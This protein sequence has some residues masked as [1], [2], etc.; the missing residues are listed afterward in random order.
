M[1]TMTRKLRLAAQGLSAAALLMSSSVALAQTSATIP[2]GMQ[3]TYELTFTGSG[4]GPAPLPNGT[5][6]DL[7][8]APGGATCIADYVLTSPTLQ[9]GNSV[10]AIYAVPSLGIKLA[11]SNVSTGQF[12]EVNVMS[13]SGQFLGQFTG[14]KKSTST[15]CPLLGSA[16]ADLTDITQII[17][18]AEQQFG[19][20]FPSAVA[21]NAFQII[22]GFVSRN[23]TTSG[24]SIG[25]KNGTVYVAGGAFG[26]TPQTIG[27]IANTL[28]QLTGGPGVEEP[29]VEVPEGDY[30]LT[31][32]GTVSAT[33]LGFTTTTPL[34]VTIDKIPAPDSSDI[35]EIEDDVREAL[36]NAEG[37]DAAT[38]TSFRVSEVS[39]S[40]SRVFFRVQFSGTIVSSG[41][42]VQQSYNLTYEYIKQ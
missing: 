7:V 13:T 9:S 10:E 12:N 31:I 8:L 34:N 27:T 36:K 32:S 29:V 40:N 21:N 17:K 20:L 41:I 42:T 30:K 25:I 19:D 24:V 14:V 37:V 28:A 16:Q 18:L 2:A 15:S 38:F 6:L 11:I 3:G 35:D 33:V 39:T 22:D 5:K 4:S 1:E 26:N 23:Y